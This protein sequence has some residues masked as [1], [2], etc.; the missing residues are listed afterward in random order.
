MAVDADVDVDVV[1]YALG[2]LQDRI[3]S[4]NVAWMDEAEEVGMVRSTAMDLDM[5]VKEAGGEGG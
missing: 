5:D 3:D 2:T 1:A 4:D